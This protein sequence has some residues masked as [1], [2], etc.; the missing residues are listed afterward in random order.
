MKCFY[1]ARI[2]RYDLL[3]PIAAL[4]K[5]VIK[6]TPQC[7]RMLHRLILYIYS[8]LDVAMYAWI[9][10]APKDLE[11]TLFCDADFAGDRGDPRS[12]TGMFLT[13]AGPILVRNKGL[14]PKV[15]LK[16]KSLLLVIALKL[17]FPI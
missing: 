13:L 7:D 5:Q 10:D 1:A 2:A 4:A 16:P 3:R 8:T 17:L 14:R 6:W 9:A 11:I 12:Q 15:L